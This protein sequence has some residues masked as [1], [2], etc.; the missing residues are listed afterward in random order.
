M[1]KCKELH[2]RI[3]CP[4]DNDELRWLVLSG[5]KEGQKQLEKE[6]S[7]N[8]ELLIKMSIRMGII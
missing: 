8:P 4:L 2:E 3:G 6:M 5:T 1:Q 7:S